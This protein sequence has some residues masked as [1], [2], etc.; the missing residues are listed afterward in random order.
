MNRL[1]ASRSAH[2][3]EVDQ[4]AILGEHIVVAFEVEG[5]IVSERRR[6]A[7]IPDVIRVLIRSRT[8]LRDCHGCT[9]GK[10]VGQQVKSPIAYAT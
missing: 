2:L 6:I 4:R 9:L 3:A 1:S 5:S 7:D 8:D 10:G